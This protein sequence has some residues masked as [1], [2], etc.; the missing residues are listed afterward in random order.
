MKST[1]VREVYSPK[2]DG[3]DRLRK[4]RCDLSNQAVD[5]LEALPEC[6]REQAAAQFILGMKWRDV[7]NELMNTRPYTPRVDKRTRRYREDLEKRAG[8]K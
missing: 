7:D 6:Y 8:A 1:V 3:L 5:L 4:Q 2:G